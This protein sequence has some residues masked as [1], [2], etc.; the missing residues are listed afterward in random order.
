S[1]S[2]SHSE[3]LFSAF[4]QDQ[5]ALSPAWRLTMGS[6]FD[7]NDF[8]GFEIQPTARLQWMGNQSM[9]WASISRAV[10][11]PS[12]LERDFD[13]V[14]GVIP[15]NALIPAPVSVELRPND[16]FESEEL[17]AYEVGYRRQ[18]TPAFATDLAIFRNVYDGL[19]T[20]SLQGAQIGLSPVVHFI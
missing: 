17:V 15:P 7:F 12:E 16:V 19:A 11:S 8:S 10:R 4:F 13:V 6:K 9:A 2:S 20:N 5:I 18:W 1:S 14:T 3:Q